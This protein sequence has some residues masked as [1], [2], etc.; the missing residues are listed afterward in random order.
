[1]ENKVASESKSDNSQIST[2]AN[3]AEKEGQAP[4]LYLKP[5]HNQVEIPD[6]GFQAWST[7]AGA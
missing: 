2:S 4:E 5:V 6:G 1:M 3:V 7:L